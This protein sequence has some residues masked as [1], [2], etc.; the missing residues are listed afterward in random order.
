MAFAITAATAASTSTAV[1]AFATAATAAPATGTA[2]ALAGRAF[3]ARPR[4]IDGQGPALKVF[5]MKHGDGFFR[6]GRGGHFDE[7]KAARA[8]GRSILHDVDRN[9]AAGLGKKILQVVFG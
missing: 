2:E 8:A 4:F 5:L 9:D 1:A 6:V 7:R 3:F